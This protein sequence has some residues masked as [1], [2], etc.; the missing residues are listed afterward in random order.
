MI[1]EAA[2]WAIFLLPLA[3]FVITVF[4]IR[5]FF[6]RASRFAGYLAILTILSSLVLSVWALQSTL[7]HEAPI[8]WSV[9]EWLKI[10]VL[11]IGVGILMDPLTAIMLVV[12][13][14][15][16][17]MVQVYSQGY[18]KA[19]PGY[20]R[21]FAYMSLFTA[22]MLGMVLASNMV[23]MFVFWELVGLCSYLLI[24]FWYH[25]PAAAAAAKKAFIVTRIGDFGLLLALLYLFLHRG[26]FAAEGL[27]V[28]L[29]SDINEGVRAGLLGSMVVTWLGL[30][31]FAGAVG[32]SAQFPL[33]VWLP[34]AME[35]PTPVSALIHAATMVAAGVFLV[36]RMFPVIEASAITMNTVA[37][38]GG[39]TAI[40]A[41]TMGLVSN[42][43]K[44]VLAYSTVSQLGYM[45]LAL[46][47]GAYGPAIFHL[48]THAFFKALLFLGSG[49]V[50]HATGTFDM[51]YMGGLRKVMPW[52]YAVMLIGSLSLAGI[53]PLAGFWS[54]DEVLASAWGAGGIVGQAV[55]WLGLVT[56][57]LTAFYVFR[58][59]YMTFH[60]SFRGQNQTDGHSESS[61]EHKTKLAE[62]PWVMV[63]PMVILAIPAILG[64]YLV[65]APNSLGAIP[66][67]WLSSFL[68]TE[69]VEFH[70]PHVNILLAIISMLVALAGIGLASLMYLRRRV[71][72]ETLVQKLKPLHVL[73]SR[74]Y[75]MDELYEDLV[76]TR[77]LYKGVS[78][79]AA[80][81][82]E[83]V[84]DRAV[85]LVGWCT[86]TIGR[87]LTH[88]QTGQV[89]SYGLGITAG[90]LLI[91]VVYLAI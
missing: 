50:N 27:N 62:S 5:P 35:G 82:D 85:D 12:V 46:G 54:K 30:G 41:A 67:H 49:S 36:A 45:M 16:S 70:A 44:R 53:F 89:Q 55:F 9:H 91:L 86:R 3:S 20:S 72:P 64:G 37:L 74:K 17:L 43:I 8:G 6:N 58:M 73:A 68:S 15:V 28:F 61:G 34:D 31:I 22:A 69:L 40:F 84:I 63:L 79:L 14:G 51:R 71:S 87:L 57:F 59:F 38:I 56:V 90:L 11:D 39:F 23:Q 19:D 42:D 18:M 21:Y 88:L 77:F 80:W 1:P 25:R 52:T 2:A 33:H 24:G 81:L 13:T 4:V 10:G 48:L 32:K 65:N 83:A 26:D 29:I 7:G 47:V 66:A 60:G 75:Y 78:R 76:V